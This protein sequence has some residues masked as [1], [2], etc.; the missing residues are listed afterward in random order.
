M[1]VPARD[2]MDSSLMR[3]FECRIVFAP[4]RE[5]SPEAYAL[6]YGGASGD[7]NLGAL[8]IDLVWPSQS[9]GL[10]EAGAMLKEA[11]HDV[12]SRLRRQVPPGGLVYDVGSGQGWFLGALVHAGFAARGVGPAPAAAQTVARHG[13]P[14]AVG[15]MES[16]P[17][18]WPSPAA[19]TLFEVV[20]HLEDPVRS[21]RALRGRFPSVPLFGS[22]PSELR[23][24]LLFGREEWDYPPNHLTR[25]TPHALRRLF[26]AAGYADVRVHRVPPT[27]RE[28]AQVSIR[29]MLERRLG[30]FDPE[31][32]SVAEAPASMRSLTGEVAARRRK[33]RL[34]LPAEV[35]AR[36]LRRTALS[37]AFE[38]VP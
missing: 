36:L 14:V 32:W 17:A 11:Q 35:V 27:A 24:T 10:A 5:A 3:C 30:R 7:S 9:A 12:L 4:N 33:A 37:W 13:I 29:W 21:L 18:E 20:E 19:V 2:R 25:W 8:A 1:G 22:V 31:R 28:M 38:A 6:A 15:H 34:L 23:W 16:M 26:A